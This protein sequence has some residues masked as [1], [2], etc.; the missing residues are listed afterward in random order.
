M[1]LTINVNVDPGAVLPNGRTVVANVVRRDRL[2]VLAL[3]AHPD[4]HGDSWVTW[5]VSP[6]HGNAWWGHYFDDIREAV[7]DLYRR[8]R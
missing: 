7:D 1:T 5:E 4:R 2:Y 3:T 8:G 6:E